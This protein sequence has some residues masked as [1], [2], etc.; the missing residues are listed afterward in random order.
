MNEF[1]LTL[2][3]MLLV[4]VVVLS[5]I[6]FAVLYMIYGLRKVMGFI[7]ARIGPNR[8]GPQGLFQTMADALKLLQK[9]DVIPQG[10]DRWL[11]TIA[12]II[13][14]VPAYLVYVVMPFGDGLIAKDLNIGVIYVSAITS[15]AVIGI[16]VAGWASNNKW[17]LLGAF[18]AAAQLVAYE[19]PMVLALCIPV[20]FAGTLRMDGIVTQQSG[21]HVL[22][23]LPNWF[24]F[25][26]YGIPTV[27]A[28][29]YLAAG[30]AE[31][32]HTPFDIMEAESE[33]V[34]GFNVEYSGMK[35]AL[36]FLEEFAASFTISAIAVTLFFGG[37][38]P[39]LHILG[40]QFAPQ[41]GQDATL[42]WMAISLFWFLAKSIALVLSL[43]W[44]RA[45]WPRVRVD[46]L[47]NFG[48]KVL[49]PL[50][51]VLMLAAGFVV[52]VGGS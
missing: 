46:Q 50:G 12:P 39:P 7:Q 43:M 29:I 21:Y 23:F 40:A 51:L 19:V 9:E 18:R 48:W 44:I 8:V 30:L 5:F 22:G 35:F 14:F 45:T 25:T 34:A 42:L 10:A 2:G 47:M 37:W 52:S 28:F 41:A 38:N 32:N 17:S 6:L 16:V 49:I 20:I 31:I 11:F 4:A 15:I 1:L 3:K 27:A 13:V 33:L 36:F 24:I 26:G